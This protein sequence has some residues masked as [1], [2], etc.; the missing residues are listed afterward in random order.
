MRTSSLD[1]LDVCPVGTEDLVLE[2]EA[3][4]CS[5]SHKFCMIDAVFGFARDLDLAYE[6]GEIGSR[7]HLVVSL[8]IQCNLQES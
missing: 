1:V 4:E 2:R 3:E 5:L 6:E 8:E 7:H